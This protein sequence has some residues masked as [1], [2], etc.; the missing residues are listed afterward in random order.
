M[1]AFIVLNILLVA[2][3]QIF[4]GGSV[5]PHL[6]KQTTSRAPQIVDLP[7][8]EER[9]TKLKPKITL[10]SALKLA[11]RYIKRN[12]IDISSFYLR[13][14]R[15]IWQGGEKDPKEPYWFFWWVNE[16]GA[17]G[18]YVEITVSMDSRVTRIPSM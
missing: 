1:L 8:P 16:S 14:A 3:D 13:E 17:L 2:D 7:L 5:A 9:F 18:N 6:Q 4:T 15:L 12:K 11:E 10:Q